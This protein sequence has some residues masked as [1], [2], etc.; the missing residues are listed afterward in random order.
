MFVQACLLM[1]DIHEEYGITVPIQAVETHFSLSSTEQLCSAS[2]PENK[3]CS[4]DFVV[5]HND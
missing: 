3:A 5:R 2:G 1:L 4:K